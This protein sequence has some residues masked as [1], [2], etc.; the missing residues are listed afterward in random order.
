MAYS[1]PRPAL[2][3]LRLGPRLRSLPLPPRL[4]LRLV[5]SQG[6]PR[7]LPLPLLS[8][9]RLDY[10]P[11]WLSRMMELPLF[12]RPQSIPS[13]LLDASSQSRLA[14]AQCG[15]ARGSLALHK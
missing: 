11:P 7:P 2:S 13:A 10:P 12:F 5:T 6:P 15:A 3:M 8:P 14:Q 4:R 1:T 9:V